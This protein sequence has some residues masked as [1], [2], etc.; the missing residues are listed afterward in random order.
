[1]VQTILTPEQ[2]EHVTIVSIQLSCLKYQLYGMLWWLQRTVVH[3]ALIT[4]SVIIDR[5]YHEELILIS[6]MIDYHINFNQIS[7]PIQT[8]VETTKDY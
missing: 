1:M 3:S 8:I 5:L 4:I 6:I 2:T 7:H